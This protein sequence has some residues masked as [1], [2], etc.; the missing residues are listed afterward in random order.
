MVWRNISFTFQLYWSRTTE[1]TKARSYKWTRADDHMHFSGIGLALISRLM[2][3]VVVNHVSSSYTK[4][5]QKKIKASYKNF[6]LGFFLV[7]V[8]L[9]NLTEVYSIYIN[10]ASVEITFAY[11][12]VA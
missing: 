5:F 4:T 1:S 9:C 3:A 2:V 8:A 10:D 11:V 7:I 6:V 12:S